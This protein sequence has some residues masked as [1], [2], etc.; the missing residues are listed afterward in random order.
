VFSQQNVRSVMGTAQA[1]AVAYL[2]AG[3]AG[4]AVA[5]HTPTEVKAA[6]TGSGRA[7]K[8]QVGEMVR[9]LL[10]LREL[11]KPA[12]AADAAAIAICQAWR[13][14]AQR[15]LENARIAASGR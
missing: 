15:R 11:P 8:S 5:S 6:I 10:G 4:I 2:V 13:G 14:G 12:D 7:E 9:R 3:R 1:A